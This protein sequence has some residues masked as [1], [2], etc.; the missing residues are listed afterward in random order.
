MNDEVFC[1]LHVLLY[2]CGAP[3]L[4]VIKVCITRYVKC[5]WEKGMGQSATL[6][7]KRV[8]IV[9]K[10][11]VKRHSDV[12]VSCGPIVVSPQLTEIQRGHVTPGFEGMSQEAFHVIVSQAGGGGGIWVAVDTGDRKLKCCDLCIFHIPLFFNHT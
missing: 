5:S 11:V 3:D 9:V 12:P 6:P 2:T 7:I 8:P 10:H 4:I 1:I